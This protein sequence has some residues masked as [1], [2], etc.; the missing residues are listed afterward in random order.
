[1]T[2]L[3]KISLIALLSIAL[4]VPGYADR[5]V[6]KKTKKIIL[7]LP[8]TTPY[9][10][11]LSLS[12]RGG[13]RYKGTLINTSA[14]TAGPS[15]FAGLVTYQKGNSLYILPVKQRIIVPEVRQGYTGMKL[16]I[17]SN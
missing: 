16:I 2:R 14:K 3:A 6:G 4:V 1:M 9:A 17:K 8:K 10:T 13:L 11:S 7:N 15:S 5:G 12:L